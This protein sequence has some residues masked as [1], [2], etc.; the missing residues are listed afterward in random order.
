MFIASFFLS[1][2]RIQFNEDL[3]IGE[4]II[5]KKTKKQLYLQN[6]QKKLF[7]FEAPNLRLKVGQTFIEKLSRFD[8]LDINRLSNKKF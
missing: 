2:S 1:N 4:K 8:T 3:T 6:K 5:E 7:G